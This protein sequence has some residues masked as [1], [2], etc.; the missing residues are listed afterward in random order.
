MSLLNPYLKDFWSE[1]ARFRV[2]HGGRMSSKS[3]DAAG[4]VIWL[5]TKCKMRVV[6]CRQFQNKIT[7]SVYS[8]LKIKIEQFGLTDQFEVTEK[9][10]RNV[11]TG[12]EFMFYGLARN[13]DEVKSLESIDIAWLEE[14]HSLTEAQWE[15]LGPTFMRKHGSQT[16]I[17]F[18]PRF[19]TDFVYKRFVTN[20]PPRTIVRQINYVDNPFLSPDALELI[21]AAKAEDY[22]EYEHIY[23]GVPR[24]SDTAA[25]IRRSWVQSAID[26]HKCIKPLMGSWR[27]GAVLGYDVADEGDD[28]N[29]TVGMDGSVCVSLDEWSGMTDELDKS[30]ARVKQ[31]ALAI[32]AVSIGYDSIG[33]GAGT[34]AHLNKLEWKRHWKFNAGDKVAHPERKYAKSGI[35]NKDFFAN[36]KAQAWWHLA[37]RFRN[38]HLALQSLRKEGSPP[39]YFKAEDMISIDST[40]FTK[41]QLEQMMD[42]L[43]TPNKDYD[44]AGRVKVESK[45]DLKKR[46]IMSPNVADA[47]VIANAR[48]LVGSHRVRDLL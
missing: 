25:V 33:V 22:E 8:L 32:E 4:Y 2:L 5:A 14:A 6:C 37:D 21:N 46:D 40:C 35:A 15:V 28:K 45:K 10:I 38:T 9:S 11:N 12:T 1:P 43:S 27:G 48:S 26:A 44:N 39:R 18:N 42:E 20:P 36:L 47:F 30:A 41:Q 13:I 17:I 34:G 29:A 23:L 3:H 31:N 16:W 24:D 7:E 19:A